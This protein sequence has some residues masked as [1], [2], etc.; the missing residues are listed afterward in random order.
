MT[1]TCAI[2]G[3]H[4]GRSRIEGFR[5]HGLNQPCWRRNGSFLKYFAE[6]YQGAHVW[7]NTGPAGGRV[8]R[9]HW[10]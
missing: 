5:L 1:N 8:V 10:D 4:V 7:T 3:E 2:C 6:L 9:D